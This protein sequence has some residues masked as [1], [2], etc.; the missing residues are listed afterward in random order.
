VAEPAPASPTT[1][2]GVAAVRAPWP[3]ATCSRA[4]AVHL[5]AFTCG[6]HRPPGRARGPWRRGCGQARAFDHERRGGERGDLGNR[7]GR[8]ACRPAPRPP[9]L[10]APDARRLVEQDVAC[11]DMTD[12]LSLLDATARP[13]WCGGAGLS[14][15]ARRRGRRARR[16][17]RPGAQRRD[18]PPFRAGPG[19]GGR[20]APRRPFR[21]VPT[22]FKDP[23]V[24]DGGR[25]LPRGPPSA[26]GCRLP[27]ARHRQPRRRCS[28]RALVCL[29]RTNTPEIG[30][31]PTTEPPAYGPTRNPWDTSRHDGWLQ[32]RL[33]RRGWR[34]GWCPWP[35]A[36][37]AAA[38]SASRRAAAASWASSPAAAGRR[39]EPGSADS[40]RR[41]RSRTSSPAPSATSPPRST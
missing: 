4:R 13:T 30:L 1:S 40:P 28:A 9:A 37:T 10:P 23:H 6:R 18:P 35:T 33:G 26:E 21:G 36:T 8:P 31:V 38:R 17:A 22:L 16:G 5:C 2:R 27:L 20:R 11:P 39:S 29:G 12:D 41:C 25:A 19:R 24:R 14:H 34:A 15:R 7:H 3:R 32:R